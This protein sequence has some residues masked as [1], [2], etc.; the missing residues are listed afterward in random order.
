M[1]RPDQPD[2]TAEQ[3]DQIIGLAREGIPLAVIA[4][5]FG[6]TRQCLYMRK[7]RPGEVGTALQRA[8][9]LARADYVI[10]LHRELRSLA[11]KG[12]GTWTGI[13]RLLQWSGDDYQ[14]PGER[15][16]V[17]LDRAK[18]AGIRRGDA[19]ASERARILREQ[20]EAAMDAAEGDE[21]ASLVRSV[22]PEETG[23]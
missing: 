13:A 20:V 1:S 4:A 19:D 3:C 8:V 18:L 5:R 23:E 7:K 14:T 21:N 17:A 9:R 12:I 6:V 15:A 11:S 22:D 16:A 2:L 10:G